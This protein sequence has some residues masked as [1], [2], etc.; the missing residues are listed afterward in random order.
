MAKKSLMANNTEV[1]LEITND[2]FLNCKHCS[3]APNKPQLSTGYTLEDV[4]LFLRAINTSIH[5]QL[6]GGE[7]LLYPDLL[8]LISRLKSAESA[9]QIGIFTSGITKNSGEY[10]GISLTYANSLF[11][12]GMTTCYI[13]IYHTIPHHHDFINQINGSYQYVISSIKNLVSVGISVKIHLV[14]NKNNINSLEE[15][16]HTLARLGVSEI[17]FLRMAKS[18]NAINNWDDIGLSLEQQ[19]NAITEIFRN[20]NRFEIKLTFSGFPNMVQCRSFDESIKCQAGIRLFYITYAG[21]VFPCACTRNNPKH[22]ISHISEIQ[23]FI[24]YNKTP[25]Y[26]FHEECLNLPDLLN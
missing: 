11:M 3:S 7:P 19:N 16:I 24:D 12:A 9:P 17:R 10:A 18:G 1:Q 14:I 20:K 15:I 22:K 5:L 26:Q 25:N 8:G 2:C 13:S 21:D 23:R 6:T 4:F